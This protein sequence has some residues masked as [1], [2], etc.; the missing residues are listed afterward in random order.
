M[1]NIRRS[2]NGRC[3]TRQHV[4]LSCRDIPLGTSAGGQ[5]AKAIIAYNKETGEVRSGQVDAPE[6]FDYYLI[7]L[8]GVSAK[9]GWC[10]TWWYAIRTTTLRISHS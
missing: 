8:D 6:G 1:K 3:S 10:S 9:A 4:W 7:K 2:R 5:R